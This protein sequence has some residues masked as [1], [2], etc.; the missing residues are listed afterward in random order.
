MNIRLFSISALVLLS[1]CAS[2]TPQPTA[3][4]QSGSQLPTA[5]SHPI[6]PAT[7][8]TTAPAAATVP[9]APQATA[10]AAT[11]A[12]ANASWKAIEKQAHELGYK[13]ETHDGKQFY[14]RSSVPT[15]SHFPTHECILPD[16][17]QAQV[18]AQMA[19]KYR[20]PTNTACL[21]SGCS[22]GN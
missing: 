22:K 15:G 1:A 18:Q 4:L 20:L 2:T 7:A 5:T 11:P 17:L 12:P 3:S 9:A 10:A 14:C 19:E 6:Q 8:Q 21:N 13:L 16:A